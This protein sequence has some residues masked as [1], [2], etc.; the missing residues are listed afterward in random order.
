MIG[1]LLI[2]YI[3]VFAYVSANKQKIIRQVTQEIGKK[4]SGNVNIGD[5]E[6][7]FFSHFPEVS[8]VLSNVLITDTL[9]TQHHHAFFQGDKVYARVGLIKLLKG[10]PS[11]N[12]IRIDH[13]SFYLFTDSNGYSNSYLYKQKRDSASQAAGSNQK[14]ELKLI[15]LRDV[16]IIVDDRT[17]NKLH[18]LIV[19]NL[20]VS[21]EDRDSTFFEFNT[22]ADILVHSLAFNL[23]RGSFVRDKTLKGNFKIGYDKKQKQ[24]VLDSIDFKLSGHPFNVTGHF[25]LAGPDPQFDM[26]IHT[27]KILY[28]FAKSLLTARIVTAFSIVDIDKKLDLDASLVG[29]LNGGDPLIHA[30][31]VIE[32]THLQT[33]F[34]DFD[35]ASFKGYYTNEVV[36]GLPRKD[37]NSNIVIK[38]FSANWQGFPI[39]SDKIEILNLFRPIMTCDLRSVFSLS[40][41]NDL[42]GSNSIQLQAGDGTADLT[43][44]GP[45]EKNNN[46][47]SFV[48][49]VIYFKNGSVLYPP[50]NVELHN[51]NGRLLFK[52]SDIIFENL[53]CIILNNKIFMDGQAKNL[54]TLINTEPNKVRLNW[55]I[56][57]PS[58]NLASF[59][60]LLK[61]RGKVSNKINGKNGLAKIA[62]A[63]DKVLDEGSLDVSLKAGKLVYKKFQANNVA[64]SISLLQ[65]SYV[66]NNVSMEHAGGHIK[67]NGSL[68][69]FNRNSRNDNIAKLYVGLD[70]VDVSKLFDAFNN[71]GQDGITSESLEGKLSAKV[72]VSLDVDDNGK[73]IPSSVE[74]IVDFSLKNGALINYEPVKKLQNFLFKNR[75]FDNIRF[76]ELKDKLEIKNQEIRINRMEIQS[77]VMSMFVEGIY[78]NKGSTDMSIQVPFNNIKKRGADFNP[79]NIGADKKGGHG[80]FIRGRPGPDGNIK[81]KLDLFNKFKKEKAKETQKDG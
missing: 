35:D 65:S 24:L 72:N 53:Q 32:G 9:F 14:S 34:L 42:I 41:L 45:L 69:Q 80:I 6:L 2:L 70:N 1:I 7:S 22:K 61:S 75:D 12:G 54:L 4:L 26:R 50:R 48:N 16:R 66:I 18:D 10:A 37:P 39:T 25:D 62:K 76:A 40:T 49:G 29:P 3:I 56:Y 27:S 17:K 38:D 11:I 5:V 68:V 46:T 55:N 19:H 13:G 20:Y 43:Y 15:E 64:A 67:V 33:P 28:S 78:S 8:V 52:N 58:L 23:Q 73:V 59:I 71:F 81:F 36:A 51:V 79:E 63:I 60:F 30:S 21:L 31:W 44:K 77:S 57:S 74:S 47:N